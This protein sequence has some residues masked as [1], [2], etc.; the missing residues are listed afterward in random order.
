MTRL[1]RKR[2]LP[3]YISI[4]SLVLGIVVL[5]TVLF[6]WISN[7][8]SSI[9]ALE[10]ADHLFTEIN[11]KVAERYASA[12]ESVAVQCGSA[13]LMPSMA[14][15]PEGDELNHPALRYMLKTIM[16]F[17]YLF[18]VYA[19][20]PDGQFLQVIAMRDNL[21]LLKIYNAPEQTRYVIR[22]ILADSAGQRVEHLRYL[23]AAEE[24]LQ[25]NEVQNPAFDPKERPWYREAIAADHVIFT[26]PYVFSSSKLPGI[27]CARKLFHGDGVFGADITLDRFTLS[28]QRQQ[29][30]ANGQLILFDPKG[31][32][33]AHPKISTQK[34]TTT[35]I[36][37]QEVPRIDF[38]TAEDSHDPVTQA[39]VRFYTD[40]PKDSDQDSTITAIQGVPYFIR[41]LPMKKALHF[42]QVLGSAAPL[43]D[44]TAHI[45]RMQKR[46]EFLSCVVLAVLLPMVLLFSHRISRA[47][48]RLERES[49]KVRRFDFSES[50]PF[51]SVIKEIHA[52]IQAFLIMKSTIRARTDALIA[53]QK[54]LEILVDSGIA[55]SAEKDMDRLLH[56]IF[57]AARTLANADGG[58]LYIRDSEDRLRFEIMQTASQEMVRGHELAEKA[59]EDRTAASIPI[60]DPDTGAENHAQVES[61]VA[62]TGETIIISPTEEDGRFQLSSICK[63]DNAGHGGCGAF[64]TVA[65]K[66]REGNN[67]GV[68]QVFNARSVKSGELTTFDQEVVGFVEALAAQAAVA[69]H[70]KRLLDEQRR[71]FDAFIQLIA[72]AIDAKSPYTGG[73]CARVPEVAAL[74][75]KAA[76]DATDGPFAEFKLETED[77]W[78]EFKV[79]AWLHDCGKVTTP[80]YVVDKATKLETI[81]NRIHE[82]RMRF[83]VLWR[84]A[85]IDY[86]QKRA[87]G[88]RDDQVLQ[89][90]LEMIKKQLREEFE[91]VARCNE[92]GEFMADDQIERLRRIALRTWHRHFDDRIGLSQ[93][94]TQRKSGDPASQL[95][96]TEHLLSDK[97]EHVIPRTNPDP[98]EGNPFGFKMEVPKD[99]YNLGEIYNLSVRRGTLTT[100]ERYKINEHI[101]QTIM[102]LKKLPFPSYL[103]E[104]AEFAGAHHETMNGRGYPRG[105]KKQ[106]MSIPA[107]IMA[108]ADI[109]EALTAA[110]RP[111]KHPKTLSESLRIMSRMRDDQHIDAD[112]FDLFLKAGVPLAYARDFMAPNQID[113]VDSE[114]LRR[115]S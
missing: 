96:V 87:T 109:F 110:D 98:F 100:E 84:D 73:H 91:F 102:M 94:E 40:R 10:T 53:T 76:S 80:E 65:L 88:T 67:I 4:S 16:H 2:R 71:L 103:Q 115:R 41:L 9:A 47:L 63:I 77:Q 79:A 82:I 58:T 5:L 113:E 85:E 75:A 70:N 8:E 12:L 108:I 36:N 45:R 69:L 86:Y 28:L 25:S 34:T 61:H 99:L 60:F 3:F 107:R 29:V 7:R 66:P 83:E 50:E 46:T 105:L 93:E 14:D 55:L 44:F 101:I 89:N 62:L 78:R 52:N 13:A 64:L 42:D 35:Q 59:N 43:S 6:L 37:G 48:E 111:Y 23:N 81:Y 20:Y 27:T 26:D 114:E 74:L 90:E 24:V 32:V 19:A 21:G 38:I 51:D 104:V 17:E 112:L 11:Q 57:D 68:M 1:L 92:G 97:P 15:V 33:L 49:E 22:L 31:R 72:G 39:I 95:P 56:T 106:E 54:K 30:S 18:S